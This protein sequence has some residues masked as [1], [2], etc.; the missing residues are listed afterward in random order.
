MFQLDP[1]KVDLHDGKFELLLVRRIKR[2][3]DFFAMLQK[4]RRQEYDGDSLLLLQASEIRMHFDKP[5]DWSLD[6]EFCGGVKEVDF[7]VL[8]NA[9]RV[10]SPENALLQKPDADTV[11]AET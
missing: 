3:T 11:T 8:P 7:S 1:Q 6:G 10:L 9:I 2:P 4:I 5:Q